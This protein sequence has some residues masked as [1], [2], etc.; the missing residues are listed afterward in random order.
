MASAFILIAAAAH[1]GAFVGYPESGRFGLTF[2]LISVL[3]WSG[4][5][6]FISQAAAFYRS[7]AKTAI[8]VVFALACVFSAVSFLPQKDGISVLRKLSYG[9]YPTRTS[10][11][12]GLLRLGISAPRILPPRKEEPP[13]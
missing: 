10:V 2:L 3:L 13:V 11:Y 12:F 4:L 1:L 7:G 5:G 6:G 8:A 9:Q